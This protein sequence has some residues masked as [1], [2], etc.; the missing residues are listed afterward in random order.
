MQTLGKPMH[1]EDPGKA[2]AQLLAASDALRDLLQA[3]VSSAYC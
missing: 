3:L 2:S 1:E